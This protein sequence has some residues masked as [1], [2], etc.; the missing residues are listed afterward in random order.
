MAGATVFGTADEMV[1]GTSGLVGFGV[2]LVTEDAVVIDG[3]LLVLDVAGAM[4]LLG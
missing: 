1:A 3:G 2:H 4:A